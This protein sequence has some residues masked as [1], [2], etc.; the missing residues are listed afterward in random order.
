VV[1][2]DNHR[3]AR[4]YSSA[5]TSAAANAK[6]NASAAYLT[7]SWFQFKFGCGPESVLPGS[8]TDELPWYTG[9]KYG[10][11]TYYQYGGVF[12]TPTKGGYVVTS[13]P[14]IIRQ[15]IAIQEELPYELRHN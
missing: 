10:G 9:S 8:F 3:A 12:F 13:P 5:P 6:V 2:V 15:N 7:R 11:I 14:S 1:V 4:S